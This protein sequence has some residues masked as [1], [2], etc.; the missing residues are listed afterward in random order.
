MLKPIESFATEDYCW[1]VVESTRAA[2]LIDS[3]AYFAAAAAALRAAKHS[4]LLIGWSIHPRTVLDPTAADGRRV[5]FARVL[6]DL[7]NSRPGLD[8]RILIWNMALPM[9]AKS[10]FVPQRTALWFRNTPVQFRLDRTAPIGACHH[11]KILVVDDAVAFSGSGDFAAERWDTKRHLDQDPRRRLPSGEKYPPRHEVMM[12]VEGP[13]AQAL[14]DLA[15]ERWLDATGERLSPPPRRPLEEV[16]LGVDAE[17][18][19]ARVAIARTRPESGERPGLRQNEALYLAMITAAER[20]IYLENQYFCSPVIA[21]ALARRLQEPDGPEVVVC[22]TVHSPGF[23]DWFCMDSARDHLIDLLRA[24][25]RFGRFHI[26]GPYTKGGKPIIVHSKVAVID[27]RVLRVGSS[28]ISNRSMAL[29]TECD[30]AIFADGSDSCDIRSAIARNRDRMLGHFLGR[31]ADDVAAAVG[32]AGSYHGAIA[33]LDNPA[34]P[35]LRP[36]T[37]CKLGLMGKLIARYHLGDPQSLADAWR[38]WRRRRGGGDY[39]RSLMRS[40]TTNGK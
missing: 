26:Y 7:A 18:K 36:L 33:A 37:A 30:L 5:P 11:Q 23:L 15:R 1:R 20:M 8:V 9:A 21:K 22:C 10:G 6:I 40:S 34:S 3:A 2:V 24:A 31:S 13:A 38:P 27:D 39:L 29:D 19:D 17:F 4:V 28:N 25:D 16:R 35:R 32:E 14:G 12:M